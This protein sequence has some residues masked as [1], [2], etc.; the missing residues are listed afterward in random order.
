MRIRSSSDAL[1]VRSKNV[2]IGGRVWG[3]GAGNARSTISPR[4]ADARARTTNAAT[5]RSAAPP[6][7][8]RPLWRAPAPAADR[9]YVTADQR[10]FDPNVRRAFGHGERELA[11]FA[12]PEI[13]R[14]H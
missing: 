6:H 9:S 4:P 3:L 7:H 1:A 11:A 10:L 5:S 12:A 13:G 8:R 14:A 2:G